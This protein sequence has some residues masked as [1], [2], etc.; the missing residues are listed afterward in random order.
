VDLREHAALVQQLPA[1]ISALVSW[2]T[3]ELTAN[4][5]LTTVHLLHAK[6]EVHASMYPEISIAT[7]RAI[8]VGLIVKLTVVHQDQPAY[9]HVH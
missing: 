3:Q 2:D 1:L 9:I 8:G 5:L 7:V 4:Q 6:M